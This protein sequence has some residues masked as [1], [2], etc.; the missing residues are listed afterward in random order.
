MGWKQQDLATEVGV[1]LNTIKSI[2]GGKSE[3]SRA[4]RLKI[5]AA[6][7]CDV[8]D[9]YKEP[10]VEAHNTQTR[11]PHLME[12]A[13]ILEF[14]AGASEI[15]RLSALWILTDKKIYLEQLAKLPNS[16]PLLEWIKKVP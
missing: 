13:G 12:A 6:F 16:A 11:D 5:A 9:L 1:H 8:S 14:W 7:G 3:G 4:N 15:R 2:E 10:E